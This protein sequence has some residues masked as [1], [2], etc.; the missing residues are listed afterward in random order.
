[1]SN[2]HD[3]RRPPWVSWW[4]LVS[5]IC[6]AVNFLSSGPVLAIAFWLREATGWNE[7][8]AVMYARSWCGATRRLMPIS[9]GG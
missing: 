6:F 5:L 7:F 3:E 9:N 4:L 8:Y 2:A 1:M